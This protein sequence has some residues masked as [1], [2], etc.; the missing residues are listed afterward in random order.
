MKT[1]KLYFLLFLAVLAT[2]PIKCFSQDSILQ[3]K[4]TISFKNETI[5]NALKSIEKE[6]NVSFT[7]S[8]FK[9]LNHKANRTFKD[10]PLK[11]VL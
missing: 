10:Q 4:I 6:A 7:Y 11:A 8:N 9:A 1:T 3:T 5:K 2:L